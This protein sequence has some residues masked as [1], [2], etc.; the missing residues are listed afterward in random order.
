MFA[1]AAL[2]VLGI[3]MCLHKNDTS[4]YMFIQDLDQNINKVVTEAE[5]SFVTPG[6][7]TCKWEKKGDFNPEK[8]VCIKYEDGMTDSLNFRFSWEL[9]PDEQVLM[10][11]FIAFNSEK[12]AQERLIPSLANSIIRQS[13]S[14]IDLALNKEQRR[15]VVKENAQRALENGVL[16]VNRESIPMFILNVSDLSSGI[17]RTNAI[18]GEFWIFVI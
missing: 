8:P 5:W 6:F 16:L 4:H 9:Q 17:N 7:R 14:G 10:S 2:V 15:Y 1:I 13:I 18:A 12:D 11:L 3:A